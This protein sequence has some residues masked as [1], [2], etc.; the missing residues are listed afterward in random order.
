[1]PAFDPSWEWIPS[2]HCRPN[3][4]SPVSGVVQH[5]T[6]AGN[7][8]ALARWLAGPDARVSAHLLI[9][10]DGH[11][12]QQVSFDSEAWHAGEVSS[13][14]LWRG[15]PQ[16]E[17]VNRFTVGIEN[18]NYGWLLK[19]DEGKFWIPKKTKQGY[20]LSRPYNGPLPIRLPDHCGVSR[21]WEPYTDYLVE[22]NIEVL[23]QL[24]DVYPN[25]TREDVQHHSAVSPHRKFDPGP[26]WPEQYV[27]DS[28]FGPSNYENL[29]IG[30]TAVEGKDPDDSE[31]NYRD[32][33]SE[34]LDMC[35]EPTDME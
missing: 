16:P 26:A 21:W 4:R 9:C 24:L 30:L 14:G 3:R 23:K 10:R 15:Q 7:G 28:V 6:G 22:K 17:N 34:D 27:L 31:F 33:Y 1:M 11:V 2:P 20:E 12:I 5:Y 25:I 35:V 8:R 13:K 18:S 32:Y 29:I 19:D